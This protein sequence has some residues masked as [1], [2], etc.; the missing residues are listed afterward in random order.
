M[1]QRRIGENTIE[2]LLWQIEAQKGLMQYRAAAMG[3]RHFTEVGAAVET[4]GRW[5]SD[6]K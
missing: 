4:D 6:L 3:A 5:P 2:G 1:E